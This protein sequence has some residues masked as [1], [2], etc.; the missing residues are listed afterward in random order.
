VSCVPLLRDDGR[1]AFCSKADV[2]V[3]QGHHSADST[4]ISI[5]EAGERWIAA[6]D[7]LERTTVEGQAIKPGRRCV[8]RK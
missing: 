6:G 5:A 1:R 8:P 2:E 4:G 7:E 3:S